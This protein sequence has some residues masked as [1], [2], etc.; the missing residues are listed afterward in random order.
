MVARSIY[1]TALLSALF[2]VG[3]MLTVAFGHG[4]HADQAVSVH[5]RAF[6]ETLPA[7]VTDGVRLVSWVGDFPRRLMVALAVA[8]FLG[9]RGHWRAAVLL[10]GLVLL[11]GGVVEYVLKPLF[12]RPRPDIIPWLTHAMASSLPSGHAAGAAV[13]FLSAALFL[14]TQPPFRRAARLLIGAGALLTVAVGISRIWLGVHWTS[15]VVA[16]WGLGT[17]A[18]LAAYAWVRPML[19]APTKS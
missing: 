8:A 16:G 9:W 7:G 13:T 19:E 14:G 4:G 2:A 11:V 1:R 17:A 10:I 5:L 15:D 6:A 12:D 18:A 3:V